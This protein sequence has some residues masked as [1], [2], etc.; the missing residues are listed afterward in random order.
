MN[1]VPARV[2][3]DGHGLDLDGGGWVHLPAAV[4]ARLGSQTGRPVILGVRP[5]HVAA[6]TGAGALPL[7]VR[8]IEP[9]GPH[10]LAIGELAG[11]RFVAHLP[12]HWPLAIG[13]PC[14]VVPDPQRLHLFDPATGRA[15]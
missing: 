8:E 14:P 2:A 10:Q 12:P 13:E 9:L 4:A 6:G 1:F 7:L 15:I 11:A 3:A 5:E